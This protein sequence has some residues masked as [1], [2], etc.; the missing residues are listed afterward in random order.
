MFLFKHL[1]LFQTFGV[2]MDA[3]ELKELLY[4]KQLTYKRVSL[5]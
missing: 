5:W 1:K 3:R 4:N 2:C